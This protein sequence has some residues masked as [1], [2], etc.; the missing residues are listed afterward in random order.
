LVYAQVVKKCR[1]RRIIEVINRVIC[2][3]GRIKELELNISTSLLERLNF[4][5]QAISFSIG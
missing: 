5:F 2:G 3:A 1:S 4:D